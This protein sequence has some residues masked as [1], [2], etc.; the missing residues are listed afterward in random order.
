MNA[1]CSMIVLNATPVELLSVFKCQA[2]KKLKAQLA[3]LEQQNSK[4]QEA[5]KKKENDLEK[6]RA[7]LK[8]T[9]G[10][11]EEETKKLNDKVA[12]LQEVN[13][14]KVSSISNYY[15]KH[16]FCTVGTQL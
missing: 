16:A 13:V 7:Q 2:E 1:L 15:Y 10:S 6:L 8:T 5:L 4:T 12:E 3:S 14:K 11:F 9:Q